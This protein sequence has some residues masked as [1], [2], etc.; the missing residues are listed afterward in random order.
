[1]SDGIT[2]TNKDVLFKVLSQHYRNKSLAV[3][4]LNI[5]KIK[6]LLPSA[7]P[8]M[9]TEHRAENVFLLEDDSLLIL[10]YESQV[11]AAD[12]LKYLRYVYSAVEQLRAESYRITNVIVA[13][14]YTGDILDTPYVYDIGALRIQIQQVFL[15]KFD[16][17]KIYTDIKSKLESGKSL[18]D[19]D[20][21]RLIVLPLTQTDKSLKQ[22]L[23]EDAVELAKQ[24]TDEAQQ[25]FIIAG[26]LT[27]TDK[28]VDREYS[29]QI[30]EWIKMTKVARLFEEEKIKAVDET[31]IETRL[32]IARNMLLNGEDILKVMVYTDLTRKEI[33]QIQLPLKA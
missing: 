7:Y 28:F 2:H 31:R 4:G 21:M 3:Y 5:P 33:E 20:V 29:N 17:S 15:S 14:I 23:T 6:K 11:L 1:M 26:I 24:V 8:V 13:V 18:S 27:A 9:T 25:L 30:K 12:F 19:D 16:S 10:E 22:Q 32:E